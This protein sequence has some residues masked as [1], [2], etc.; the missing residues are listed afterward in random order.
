MSLQSIC[1]SWVRIRMCAFWL[2]SLS[3][4]QSDQI[5]RLQKRALRLI[6]PDSSSDEALILSGLETLHA[7]RERVARNFF[8]EVLFPEHTLHH[9]LPEPHDVRYDLRAAG[10]Q[11]TNS[12]D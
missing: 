6:C 11:F 4:E 8:D 5:E 9:L 12:R 2:T 7:R 10:T 3:T 1:Q